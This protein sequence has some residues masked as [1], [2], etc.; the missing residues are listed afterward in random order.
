MTATSANTP[1]LGNRLEFPSFGKSI[2]PGKVALNVGMDAFGGYFESTQPSKDSSNFTSVFPACNGMLYGNCIVS[3][4]SRIVDSGIWREGSVDR[5]PIPMS[6]RISLAYSDGKAPHYA[7]EIKE[8]AQKQIPAG[9]N[10]VIWNLPDA[11][12][13]GGTS[14]LVSVFY[15]TFPRGTMQQVLDFRA[16]LVPVN[17]HPERANYISSDSQTTA[18]AYMDYFDFPSQVEYKISIKLGVVATKISTFFNGRIQDPQISLDDEFLVIAGKPEKFP[19]AQSSVVSYV[20][21]SKEQ[22]R[23]FQDSSAENYISRTGFIGMIGDRDEVNF[24][25]F[26]SWEKDLKEV[27]KLTAWNMSSAANPGDCR[28]KKIGGFVSSNAML[29][30]TTPPIWNSRNNSLNYQIASLHLS[31]EG[32]INVGNFDLLLHS[33]LIRCLW[34]REITE[35]S[36]IQLEVLSTE[37]ELKTST[38]SSR[39]EKEWFYLKVSNFSFSNPKISL[40]LSFKNSNAMTKNPKIKS[41]ICKKGKVV[42]KVEGVNPKCPRGFKA[43]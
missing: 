4:E 9:L 10:S 12:H 32:K 24:V 14:Y 41:L 25:N 37:G 30:S 18:H 13:A 43:K 19:I 17:F 8:N 11:P 40:K 22:K 26:N 16:E 23:V 7:G 2:G 33:D 31:N 29:Y 36:S 21:L 38:V 20:D 15:S 6:T 1:S 39:Q 5:R 28:T 35:I 3:V 42:K 34:K 27:G